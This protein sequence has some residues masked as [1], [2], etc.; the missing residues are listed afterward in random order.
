[1]QEWKNQSLRVT[2]SSESS[3]Q[4]NSMGLFTLKKQGA[5]QTILKANG[6]EAKS[7]ETQAQ[8]RTN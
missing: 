2:S 7:F 6:F 8:E 5:T 4:G 1:M 3:L